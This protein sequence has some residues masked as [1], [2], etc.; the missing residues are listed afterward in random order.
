MLSQT[1]QAAGHPLRALRTGVERPR[2][3]RAAS[4]WARVSCHADPVEAHE[5]AALCMDTGN[6][7]WTPVPANCA[8]A[9]LDSGAL[10]LL[11][12]LVELGGAYAGRCVFRL[13]VMSKD[14]KDAVQG[15]VVAAWTS[16]GALRAALQRE[17][18]VLGEAVVRLAGVAWSQSKA[19]GTPW[20]I[21]AHVSALAPALAAVLL[22]DMESADGAQG[23][24]ALSP[25]A[26]GGLVL[27]T[28][29]ALPSSSGGFIWPVSCVASIWRGAAW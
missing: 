16:P 17:R 25:A 18:A 10:D 20:L 26:V 12:R 7:Q 29:L 6:W 5:Y 9:V 2:P 27:G 3:P 19:P 8:R 28:V 15:L 21:G 1:P 14:V 23:G 24:V 22:G 4:A 13:S 11:T